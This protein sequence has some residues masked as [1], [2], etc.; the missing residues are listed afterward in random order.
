MNNPLATSRVLGLLDQLKEAARQLSEGRESSSSEF[1]ARSAAET[2]AFERASAEG[3]QRLA[4]RLAEAEARAAE[5]RDRLQARMERRR[6][7]INDAHKRLRRKAT[8][9]VTEFE[10]SRKQKLQSAA[11]EA[12]RKRD[13]DLASAALAH[14][15]FK[16]KLVE[17]EH[18]FA[19]LE[20]RGSRVFR[21]FGGFR[22]LLAAGR[23]LSE[24]DLSPDET[25]L[26]DGIHALRKNCENRLARFRWKPAPALLR[27]L[28]IWLLALIVI[29]GAAVAPTV[30]GH[31]GR[32][33]T[34]AQAGVAAGAGLAACVLLYLLARAQASG[35]A[36]AMAADLLAARR[37]HES[38]FLKNDARSQ[39]EQERIR[40]EFR[41]TSAGI[42]QQYRDVIKEAMHLRDLRPR[43]LDEKAKRAFQRHEVLARIHAERQAAESASNLERV[44]AEAE[45]AHRALEAEH[46]ERMK[47][48]AEDRDARGAA[49]ER[50]WNQNAA[51]VLK[52]LENL[53]ETAKILFPE[54]EL[55][56]WRDWRPPDHFQNAAKF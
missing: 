46:A 40:A 5:D 11:M 18:A 43:Q 26:L 17:S 36:R 31:F 28:P 9:D 20:H 1:K 45:A 2:R 16:A 30:A 3:H 52:E 49:L 10:G 22:R 19:E 35:D 41:D 56:K 37:L 32:V 55:E 14:D 27:A 24:P 25:R 54:W 6:A 53:D 7:G 15:D 13:A 8:E 48:F 29:I 34:Y 42:D 47:K 50:V 39:A 33:V 44:R 4:E 12:E 23:P 21:G 38:C 51:P